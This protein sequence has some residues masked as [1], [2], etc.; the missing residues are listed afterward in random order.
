MCLHDLKEVF[1]ESPELIIVGT[2]ASGILSVGDDMSASL[3]EKGIEIVAV[4]TP[5]AIRLFNKLSLKKKVACAL[6][7][8]C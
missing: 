2:G 3:R 4:R 1:P 6:H 7:L 8:S 5:E